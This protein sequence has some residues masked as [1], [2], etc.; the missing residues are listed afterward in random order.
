MDIQKNKKKGREAMDIFWRD[1]KQ[2]LEKIKGFYSNK[3]LVQGTK[4]QVP[5]IFWQDY[6]PGTTLS[7]G[8]FTENLSERF[9]IAEG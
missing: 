1:V 6:K 9:S 5:G 3:Y 8:Y 2:D 7:F 4:Y